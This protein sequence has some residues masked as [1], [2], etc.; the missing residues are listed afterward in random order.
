MGRKERR[1]REQKRENYASQRSSEKRKQTLIAVGV[2]AV[3]AVIV[4]YAAYIFVTMDQSA[5]PGGPEGAGNL[6]SEH[7]HANIL[8]KIFGD[9][10]DFSAPAYQIKSAWIHFEGNDGTTIHKHATG[11]SM[12]Y[13]FETLNIG[14]TDECYEFPDRSRSFCTEGENTLKFYINGEKVDGIL[15]YVFNDGD[16]ILISFGSETPE[17]IESQILELQGQTLVT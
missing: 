1:E 16:K 10:F 5:T 6:G 8:V 9:T 2:L 13:L 4:G 17:E 7:T 15:D 12:G 14:L 11:V 3:I